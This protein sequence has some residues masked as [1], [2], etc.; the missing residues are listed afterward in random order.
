MQMRILRMAA[1]W[2]APSA[3]RQPISGV[4]G[5]NVGVYLALAPI[6]LFFNLFVH[7]PWAEILQMHLH[8]G[9]G[10]YHLRPNGEAIG[11]AEYTGGWMNMANRLRL[12]R[13][14]V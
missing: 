5:E 12:A 6:C 8:G 13:G 4:R 3:Y 7:G 14:R 1:C 11:L 10:P 9:H 2:G